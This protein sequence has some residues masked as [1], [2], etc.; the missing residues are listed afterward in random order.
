MDVLP[1][2]PFPTTITC[3][4]S[5]HFQ[6]HSSL[7]CLQCDVHILLK[8]SCCCARRLRAIS[9]ESKV[10]QYGRHWTSDTISNLTAICCQDSGLK[11]LLRFKS[12]LPSLANAVAHLF[13]FWHCADWVISWLSAV[14]LKQ[15]ARGRALCMCRFEQRK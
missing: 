3:K 8:H 4:K 14:H 6:S 10:K 12:L 15:R 11:R 9:L 13:G 1:T 5:P 2:C 7:T